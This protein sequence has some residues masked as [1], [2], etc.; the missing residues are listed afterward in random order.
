[1]TGR[2]REHFALGLYVGTEGLN[3]YRAMQTKKTPRV[4]DELFHLQKCLMASF[5]D[6][7][8]LDKHDMEVLR[9]LDLKFRGRNAWP[10]FRDYRP[11]YHP[12]YLT[13]SEAEF[14]TLALEQS[15]DV[16]LRFRDSPDM[17]TP[18]ATNR[19]LV[20]VPEKTKSGLKW[21]EEWLEPRPLEKAEA[22]AEPVDR[23]TVERIKKS[24]PQRRGVWEF[25]IFYSPMAVNETRGGRPYYPY[26]FFCVERDSGFILACNLEA[27][28]EQ[29]SGLAGRMLRMM[30]STRLLP[31]EIW[32]TRED[33]LRLLG[34]IAEA[35]GIKLKSVKRLTTL[36]RAR[37][38]MFRFLA[39]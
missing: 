9:A 5:E 7:K 12:W 30:E 36:E 22:A 4:S 13:G 31:Q 33:T 11:G 26:V 21:K 10:Q 34:P 38:S 39:R 6:R 28:A 16:A 25:D 18:P 15:M 29:P 17:L 8:Y 3:G 27:P 23:A 35:L 19:Y 37:S 32:V 1:V 14:L 2:L 24:I 20:R